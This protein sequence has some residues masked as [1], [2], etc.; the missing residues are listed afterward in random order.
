MEQDSIKM[1]CFEYIE[2][3]LKEDLTIENIANAMG[4]S[5]CHFARMFKDC[6]GISTMEYV[7]ERRLIKA[8]WDIMNGSRILDVALDYGYSTHSAF[9][10]AFRKHYGFSPTLIKAFQIQN[11]YINSTYEEL[12]S[13]ESNSDMTN[14]SVGNN[15]DSQ[16]GV[17]MSI[18]LKQPSIH[19]TKEELYDILC[20]IVSENQ[21]ESNSE[22]LRS[23]YDFACQ[24]HEG[25]KRYCG[26]EY[27]TH[28]LNVAILLAEMEADEE[29]ILV[30]LLHDVLEMNSNIELSTIENDF[31]ESIARLVKQITLFNES[32][33]RGC[34]IEDMN[35]KVIMVKL[36][37]RLHNMRTIQYTS[38]DKYKERAKETLDI[39]SPIAA[40]YE[41]LKLKSELDDLALKYL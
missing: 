6:M 3:H 16:K 38:P 31:T 13:N 37:D 33:S 28:S 19:T 21:I 35:E 17:Y 9:T 15:T 8:S 32:Y 12:D 27:V 1:L 2:K 36:A 20:N 22:H 26:D 23:A 34:K 18:F 4:Y 30:G 41:N 11:S 10:K 39:F 5:T 24:A 7:K 14:N 29:T 25:Q 40:K